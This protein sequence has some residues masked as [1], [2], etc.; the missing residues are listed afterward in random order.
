MK[1]VRLNATAQNIFAS[2]A[3]L[4]VF[5]MITTVT[6]HTSRSHVMHP[7]AC[8]F[9]ARMKSA[10]YLDVAFVIVKVRMDSSETFYRFCEIG[11]N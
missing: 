8:N 4:E 5:L 3:V 1:I 7:T 6:Q 10:F 11:A 2:L 9:I